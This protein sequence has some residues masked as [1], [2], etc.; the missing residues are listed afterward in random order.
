MNV[1]SANFCGITY[2]II[3]Y[4]YKISNLLHII[5]GYVCTSLFVASHRL[6]DLV[7]AGVSLV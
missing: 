5:Y 3:M 1:Y 6:L 7:S 4:I 2:L